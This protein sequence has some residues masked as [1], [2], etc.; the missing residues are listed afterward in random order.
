MKKSNDKLIE[1]WKINFEDYSIIPILRSA[2]YIEK[3]KKQ[4]EEW[5]LRNHLPT[6][7][8]F[9]Y[10]EFYDDLEEAQ[11]CLKQILTC[12]IVKQQKLLNNEFIH[13]NRLREILS[14]TEKN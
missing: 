5:C 2:G 7:F 10:R 13:L 9:L 1:V 4:H 8:Q 6:N 11:D 12:E 3:E 14:L